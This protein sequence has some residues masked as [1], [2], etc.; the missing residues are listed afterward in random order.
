[1]K[2]MNNTVNLI[3]NLGQ[4]V[5]LQ[6]FESGNKRAS[7][8]LA[9]TS[10]FK[11]AKGELQKDT[12]WHNIVAWGVQ[13]DSMSKILQKGNMIAIKGKLQYRDYQD[14]SGKTNKITEVLVDE[15]I[16]VNNKKSASID[17]E[18]PQ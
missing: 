13:A 18:M 8:S 15:F 6:T 7:T 1:M 9:T 3:G 17:A 12:Q 11:N 4:D 5:N 2:S 16:V 14:K 10:Y